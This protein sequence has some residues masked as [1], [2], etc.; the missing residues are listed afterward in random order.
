MR[1]LRWLGIDLGGER[2]ATAAR[3]KKHTEKH[4]AGFLSFP[5]NDAVVAGGGR[6]AGAGSGL[7]LCLPRHSGMLAMDLEKN[8]QARVLFAPLR[9]LG[10]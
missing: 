8:V 2:A 3:S 1:A 10:R 5:A 6:Q 7:L 4:G 9:R